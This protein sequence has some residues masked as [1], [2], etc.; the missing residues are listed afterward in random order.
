MSANNHHG[1]ALPTW[2]CRA[3]STG[4]GLLQS[5]SELFLV[6]AQEEKSRLIRLVICGL[7]TL[8]L[9]MTT[10]LLVTGM[11]VYLAPEKYRVWVAGGF[12]LLYLLGTLG[13]VLAVRTMLK[14]PPFVET[15]AQF[16]KDRELLETLP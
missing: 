7:G 14:R 8:F 15:L 10:L 4:F 12:A 2:L 6:E 13:A 16:R 11:V 5:R 3:A 9:G 1:P